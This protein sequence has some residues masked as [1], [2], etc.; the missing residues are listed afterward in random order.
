MRINLVK[1]VV[2]PIL[3][4][5]LIVVAVLLTVPRARVDKVAQAQGC[6]CTCNPECCE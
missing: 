6:L 4:L 1:R 2:V 3:L 5:V